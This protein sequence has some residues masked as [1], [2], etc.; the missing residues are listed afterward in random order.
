MSDLLNDT[1]YRLND[2]LDKA[3]NAISESKATDALLSSVRNTLDMLKKNTDSIK[4]AKK[5]ITETLDAA[6]ELQD[7]ATSY[8]ENATNAY[9]VI[10]LNQRH[11]IS[12]RSK[13]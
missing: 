6:A 8:L 10:T 5:D 12:S 3:E 9:V 2:L 13:L 11:I 4:A 1:M 7:H